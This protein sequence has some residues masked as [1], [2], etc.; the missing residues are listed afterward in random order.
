M[1][2]DEIESLKRTIAAL[3]KE[4]DELD[5][6]N[7]D[8]RDK[9]R[10]LKGEVRDLE[11]SVEDEEGARKEAEIAKESAENA[12]SKVVSGEACPFCGTDLL[13]GETIHDCR[14]CAADAAARVEFYRRNPNERRA[15]S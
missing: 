15:A 13:H 2:G 11:D 6:E 1:S 8:L 12:L 14:K 5:N 9:V 4:R 7:T 3:E 10:D